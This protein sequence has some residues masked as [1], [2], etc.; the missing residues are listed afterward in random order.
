MAAKN[1]PPCDLCET[2]NP[3]VYVDSTGRL[4]C[5]THADAVVLG[6]W[7]DDGAKEVVASVVP[8]SGEMADRRHEEPAPW[9]C[10]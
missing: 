7:D 1:W 2:G 10:V 9:E 6:D 5:W 8:D 3:G 4:L